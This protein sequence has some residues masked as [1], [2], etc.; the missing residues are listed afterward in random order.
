MVLGKNAGAK[1]RLQP[2]TF[3]KQKN[4]IEKSRMV[5]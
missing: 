5:S 2:Q 4:K 1:R 3:L